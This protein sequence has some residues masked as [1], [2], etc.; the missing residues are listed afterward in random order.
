MS[1]F[2]LVIPKEYAENQTEIIEK[3][4]EEY[5]YRKILNKDFFLKM[6]EL[7]KKNENIIIDEIEKDGYSDIQTSIGY[8]ASEYKLSKED[9][10][11]IIENGT[12]QY[13]EIDQKYICIY[14]NKECTMSDIIEYNLNEKYKTK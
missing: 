5:F 11:M 6:M 1:K 14:E 12:D 3:M 4:M 10:D 8:L 2:K 13:Y 7:I 9:I